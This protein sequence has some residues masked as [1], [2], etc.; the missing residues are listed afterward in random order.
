MFK[1]RHPFFECSDFVH[2]GDSFAEDDH[3]SLALAVDSLLARNVIARVYRNDLMAAMGAD[4]ARLTQ[5]N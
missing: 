1:P 4:L 3:F 5:P 2:R